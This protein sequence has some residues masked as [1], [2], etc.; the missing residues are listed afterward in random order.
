[1]AQQTPE[2]VV[3]HDIRRYGA[4]GDGVT[5]DTAAIQ[6]AV[7]ACHEA[8]GG[9][10]LV[11]PGTYLTGTIFL[12]SHVTLH[13]TAGAVLKGSGRREDYN[14]DD[15]FPEN[16]V[17]ASE[18]VTGAHLIIAYQAEQ[19]AITGEGTIDGHSAAFFEPLPPEEVTTT[20]RSKS[21]NFPIRDWRPGQMVFFC[22]CRQVS[23]RDV[24]LI[25]SPYWTLLLLGC[26]S[27]QIRGLRITNPP[28]TAN[29]DGIDVDCCRQVTISDCLI[30]SGDDAITLRG[31]ARALGEHAQACEHVVVSNCLL[32]TPCT[33][34]R[35]GVGN[36]IV[37]DCCFS[38]II[39]TG[40]RTGL[41]FISAYSDRLK[42][43]VTIEDVHFVNC[44]I[45]AV[46]PL[47]MLLG[48]SAQPPAGIRNVS[49]SHCR[50][51]G[52]QG[53]YLGGNPGHRLANIRLHEV[54]LR[55]SGSEVDPAFA[56]KTPMPYGGQGVPAGLWARHVDG[57]RLAGVRVVWDHVSGPWQHAVVIEDSSDVNLAGLEAPPPPVA[58]AGEAVHCVRVEDLVTQ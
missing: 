26:E 42:P 33:G 55:M 35:I 30:N 50:L 12:R 19:V 8:G 4:V 3:H 45:D 22:R 52:E 32:S 25:N 44:Q 27:V 28:Q 57:L 53:C 14:P 9:T 40:T 18:K 39:I 17:F 58:T 46:F 31:H 13:L 10:A 24:S 51:R 34:V 23:V 48:Q 5:L 7:D 29:G 41:N 11:P 21:R 49:L 6:Q 47:N 2:H 54:E 56:E 43:G 20:Y 37:R 15:I 16:H 1:M 38:N 36:G